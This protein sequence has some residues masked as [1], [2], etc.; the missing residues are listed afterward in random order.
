MTDTW[1]NW[2]ALADVPTDPE[3]V[4]CSRVKEEHADDTDATKH[5]MRTRVSVTFKW[6]GVDLET[7]KWHVAN[8]QPEFHADHLAAATDNNILFDDTDAAQND[9][10]AHMD[11]F[12]KAQAVVRRN[13]HFVIPGRDKNIYTVTASV[14]AGG[15]QATVNFT[16][17]LD[18]AITDNTLV[19]WLLV[20]SV[21]GEPIGGG[22]W[23]ILQT[24]ET[25]LPYNEIP[26]AMEENMWP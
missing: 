9:T 10:S 2:T 12:Y 7:M 18:N 21:K 1:R 23:N 3:I 22:G 11:N 14:T 17:G 19:C 20:T 13:W 5:Y 4:D 25:V 16:P 8:F 6:A 15:N 26:Q 24:E